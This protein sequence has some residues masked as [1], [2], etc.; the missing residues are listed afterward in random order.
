MKYWLAVYRN[1]DALE[2]DHAVS[3]FCLF[4]SI[5]K[6]QY[7]KMCKAQFDGGANVVVLLGD[8]VVEHDS[9]ADLDSYLTWNEIT[10]EQ[11]QF[12]SGIFNGTPTN[13]IGSFGFFPEVNRPDV[14]TEEDFHDDQ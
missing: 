13:T 12:L 10:K 3:G 11:A 9:K 1:D 2:V 6:K 7:E 5:T 4:S 14:L 8:V